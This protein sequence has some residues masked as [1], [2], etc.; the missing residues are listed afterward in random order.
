MQTTQETLWYNIKSS[1]DNN[2]IIRQ[3]SPK[4]LAGLG[5]RYFGSAKV[6]SNEGSC[7]RRS[8]SRDGAIN[9][10]ANRTYL[11]TGWV[12]FG[13]RILQIT[14]GL[15]QKTKLNI[16]LL[17]HNWSFYGPIADIDKANFLSSAGFQFTSAINPI[18]NT[19]VKT[20]WTSALLVST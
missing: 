14:A 9:S 5:V 15:S 20:R 19:A 6:S 3:H 13:K 8:R 12:E 1:N 2:N 17:K 4:K 16:I 18:I 10:Q 11:L 7:W